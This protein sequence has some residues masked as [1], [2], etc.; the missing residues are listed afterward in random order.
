MENYKKTFAKIFAGQTISLLTSAIVQY[1]IIWYLTF[2][3][4]SAM[5][6]AFATIAGILPQ[7]LLGPFA[8]VLVDRLDR[9]KVMMASDSLVAFSTFILVIIFMIRE[10]SIWEMC[11]ILAIRSIGTTFQDV[12]K[13]QA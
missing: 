12:Y 5:V 9:K 11:F 8:G 10:P 4:G 3:T 6:L 2:K 13:R 7:I 1:A